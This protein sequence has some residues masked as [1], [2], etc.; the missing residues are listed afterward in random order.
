MNPNFS[1]F[2]MLFSDTEKK[3]RHLFIETERIGLVVTCLIIN[4]TSCE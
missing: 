1:I 3:T 4:E 2:I